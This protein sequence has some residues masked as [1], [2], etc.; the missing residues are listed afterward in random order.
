MYL[1]VESSLL[2]DIFYHYDHKSMED[3]SSCNEFLYVYYV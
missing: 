3:S 2:Y 1:R